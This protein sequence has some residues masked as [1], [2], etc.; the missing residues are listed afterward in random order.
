MKPRVR[1]LVSFPLIGALAVLLGGCS[2]PKVKIGPALEKSPLRTLAV[3]PPTAATTVPR[4]RLQILR[5][6]LQNELTNAGFVIIDDAIVDRICGGPGCPKRGDAAAAYPLDGFAEL[7]IQSAARSNFIAGYYNA[8][9]GVLEIADVEGSKLIEVRHT[10]SER[11][12]LLFNS[13]QLIEGVITQLRNSDTDSFAVLAEKFAQ[14]LVSNLP[15][16]KSGPESTAAA[17]PSIAETLITAE[18]DSVY[19]VCAI[20]APRSFGYL[21]LKNKQ[22]SNLREV[23]N[24]RYC[25]KYLVADPTQFVGAEVELRSAFGLAS[26]SPL[27]ALPPDTSGSCEGD[28]QVSLERGAPTLTSPCPELTRKVRVYKAPSEAGPFVKIAEAPGA[29]WTDRK[30]A[31]LTPRTYALVAIDRNGIQSSPKV[32]D[33][34][35]TENAP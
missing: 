8:V 21:V 26:R 15:R 23:S 20:G 27:S 19:Q 14:T 32:K 12:G 29:A 2:A 4:E 34:P 1:S 11:G 25:G 17:P 24:G 30:A 35:S 16:P 10:E 7:T 31:P 13:G 3:L 22:R 18:P 9:S 5:T 33:V 28:L 6:A